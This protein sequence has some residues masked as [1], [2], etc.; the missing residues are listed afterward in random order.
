MAQ[1]SCPYSSFPDIDR[2]SKFLLA[3]IRQTIGLLFVTIGKYG[4]KFSAVSSHSRC[5]FVLMTRN[6]QQ[7]ILYNTHETLFFFCGIAFAYSSSSNIS[8]SN[9]VSHHKQW[10]VGYRLARG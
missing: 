3:Y 1:N 4:R 8:V 2:F 5:R 6:L 10:N 7:V 9:V